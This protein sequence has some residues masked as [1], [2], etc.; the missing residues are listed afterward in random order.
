MIMNRCFSGFLVVCICVAVQS[1]NGTEEVA[2][3]SIAQGTEDSAHR[4]QKSLPNAWRLRDTIMIDRWFDRLFD[5]TCEGSH[6]Y[7]ECEIRF[8]NTAESVYGVTGVWY[9][10]VDY[11][12]DEYWKTPKRIRR[13]RQNNIRHVIRAYRNSTMFLH[14]IDKENE[15]NAQKAFWRDSVEFTASD[16]QDIRRFFDRMND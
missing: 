9:Q 4:S 10:P 2:K 12:E 13:I 7:S 6:Y 11:T 8:Y 1:C 14:N 15:L 5:T 3:N 16:V